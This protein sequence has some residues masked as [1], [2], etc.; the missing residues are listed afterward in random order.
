MCG[1]SDYFRVEFSPQLHTLNSK[2]SQLVAFGRA[3][4]VHL[5][6]LATVLI[7][8]NTQAEPQY[9]IYDMGVVQTGDSA[10][11]GFG[12]SPGGIG[13]GRSFRSNGAQAF[14]WTLGGG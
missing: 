3:G 11:Q 10:S 4:I 9:Q 6:L 7:V 2:Y 14:T 12:V 1:M 8:T 13:L 5:V